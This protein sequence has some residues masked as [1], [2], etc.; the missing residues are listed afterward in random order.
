[1]AGG[2]E[3]PHAVGAVGAPALGPGWDCGFATCYFCLSSL[4][5]VFT[6]PVSA[7]V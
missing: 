4:V 1:M 6:P 3:L 7:T 2:L 5:I